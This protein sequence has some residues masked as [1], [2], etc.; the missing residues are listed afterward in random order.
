MASQS[1]SPL[2]PSRCAP[3]WPGPRPLLFALTVCLP[4]LLLLTLTRVPYWLCLPLPCPFS[5]ALPQPLPVS[6]SQSG[7]LQYKRTVI[8]TYLDEE[9]RPCCTPCTLCTLC[10]L[11]TAAAAPCCTLC[12]LLR[13]CLAHAAPRSTPCPAPTPAPS[14]PLSLTPSAGAGAARLGRP[15]RCADAMQRAGGG[16]RALYRRAA[17]RR[18]R[19]GGGDHSQ[20]RRAQRLRRAPRV[21]RAIVWGRRRRP[22]DAK[23]CAGRPHLAYICVEPFSVWFLSMF[24]RAN[25]IQPCKE[26]AGGGRVK[27]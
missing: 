15:S 11:C 23:G 25:E 3:R 9:A 14:A 13:S 5:W 17:R 24:L 12:A 20:W 8:A 18:H 1:S 19:L 6:P 7:P 22:E 16:G 26:R 2:S 21:R 27:L 10:T 4:S